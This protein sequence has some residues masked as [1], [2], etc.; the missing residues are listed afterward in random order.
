M[1]GVPE[2]GKHTLLSN[3]PTGNMNAM[4]TYGDGKVRAR[5][6]EKAWQFNSFINELQKCIRSSKNIAWVWFGIMFK[7]IFV[8]APT[9]IN[10]SKCLTSIIPTFS[11][12][13]VG[14][15]SVFNTSYRFHYF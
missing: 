7:L 8:F 11:P 15:L 9:K 13:F 5:L 6:Y 2:K 1:N 4:L 10:F 14:A 12:S 3:L